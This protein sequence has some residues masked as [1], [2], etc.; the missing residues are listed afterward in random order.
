MIRKYLAKLFCLIMVLIIVTAFLPAINIRGAGGTTSIKITKYDA[1]GVT[2]IQQQTVTYQWMRDNLPVSGDGTTHYYHQGPVFKDDPNAATQEMLRWNPEEDNNVQDKDMGALKGTNLQVLCDLVGGME[3]GDT[4]KIKA[5]DG[6]SRQFAYK[7]VYQ[8]SSREGP[9]VLAWS[10]DGT[11]PDSGYSEGMRLVWFADT[12][13][14]P[15]GLHVFGN[16]D[17]RLAAASQCWYYY[18]SGTEKYP[19]TT[20]LSIQK[21]SELSIYS[22]SSQST[23]GQNSTVQ[24][25]APFWDLNFDHTCNTADLVTIGTQWG[26]TGSPGWIKQDVNKD[27]SIDIGDV[28][29]VGRHW[30]ETW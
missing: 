16:N 26:K 19:T 27:G 14:N 4:L 13:I 3:E 21:V 24:I 22:N 5:A 20:G 11:Y 28:I 2:V 10:K 15:W 25:T 30:N 1:N 12:S 23:G 18:Q 7:N 6:L 8:Y 9:M 17:W 29:M